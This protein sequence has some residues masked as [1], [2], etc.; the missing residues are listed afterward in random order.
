MKLERMWK[1][2][3]RKRS[4]TKVNRFFKNKMENKNNR[5]AH[6]VLL[7]LPESRVLQLEP[8][9]PFAL[10]VSPALMDRKWETVELQI[11]HLRSDYLV[12]QIPA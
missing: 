6:E 12:Y 11:W 5:R 10:G 7:A 1:K 2:M 3:M 4:N 8:L 9:D